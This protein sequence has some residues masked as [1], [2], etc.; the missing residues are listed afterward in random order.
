MLLIADCN[1]TARIVMHNDEA[2]GDGC[3]N[4][5]VTFT[6][7]VSDGWKVFRR[8]FAFRSHA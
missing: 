2:I 1:Q 4:I 3:N 6:C 5:F 8:G 7:Q